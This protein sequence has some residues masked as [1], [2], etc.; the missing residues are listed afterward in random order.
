VP[1]E[2]LDEL[3]ARL[4]KHLGPHTLVTASEMVVPPK[5]TTGSLSLDVILG[6]GWPGNQWSEIIGNESAGKTAILL[7]TIAANQRLDPSFT[8]LWV[9][10]EHFDSDQARALGVD[11]D[12][13][14]LVRTQK[15][16]L[17][18]ELVIQSAESRAFDCIALD[19]YPALLPDEEAEKAM[20]EFSVALGA[21]LFNKFWRKAGAASQRASD[22]TERPF[23]GL[24]IN[25][26]RD[27]IG[28]WSPAG[29]PQTSPGGHGKDFAYFVRLRL[30]RDEWLT[31]K[32]PSITGGPVKVGQSIKMTTLKNKAAPPQQVA[33]VDFY[34]RD[35]P[36]R[37][38][39]R[40]DYDLGKEYVRLGIE[41]GVIRGT[42]WYTFDGRKWQGKAAMQAD[43][44]A[45]M[46]LRTDLRAQIL[47]AAADPRRIFT[48]E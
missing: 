29:T 17:A 4:N 38:F 35:A 44:L 41:F 14:E 11:N 48:E 8:T 13:V 28:G 24:I 34:F 10:G 32:W 1:T 39:R 43:V 25:Q 23:I 2:T 16:E 27:K 45:E 9:A 36:V 33:A 19:S 15:M 5:F 3:K 46:E 31:E 18:L 22:G 7:K 47:A 20:D 42:G 21:K 26:F 37:G 30:A 40:G 6:G 12:R